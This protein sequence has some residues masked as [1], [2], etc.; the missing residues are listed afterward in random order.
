MDSGSAQRAYSGSTVEK[1]LSVHYDVMLWGAMGTKMKNG[2]VI[3]A[4]QINGCP[5]TRQEMRV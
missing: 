4:H 1:T 2:D 5:G 3:D